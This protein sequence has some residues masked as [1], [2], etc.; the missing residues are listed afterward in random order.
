MNLPPEVIT[1]ET[2]CRGR[3]PGGEDGHGLGDAQEIAGDQRVADIRSRCC[4]G[5]ETVMAGGSPRCWAGRPAAFRISSG[6]LVVAGGETAG[7][8]ASGPT[9]GTALAMRAARPPV[10]P[11]AS[12]NFRQ[13]GQPSGRWKGD[14][15][16]RGRVLEGKGR[17]RG[18]RSPGCVGAPRRGRRRGGLH[19]VVVGVVILIITILVRIGG[20]L[21]G[22]GLALRLGVVVVAVVGGLAASARRART[23]GRVGSAPVAATA[24]VVAGSAVVA[25]VSAPVSGPPPSA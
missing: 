16:A 17:P 23:R 3:S 11:P 21:L 24:A 14:F 6:G 19:A 4:R 12:N 1:A 7:V 25:S 15:W 2:G 5:D 18:R 8:A 9:A 10:P 20:L 22:L 13:P